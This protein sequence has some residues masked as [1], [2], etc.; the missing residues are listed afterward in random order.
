MPEESKTAQQRFDSTY[1]SSAEI[2]AELCIGRTSVLN[3]RRNLLL[4]DPVLVNNGLVWL[5]EREKVR[6][7]LDEWKAARQ[8]R[9]AVPA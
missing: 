3:A 4:P 8:R 7:I 6:P 2:C 9:Q 1:I 5:W